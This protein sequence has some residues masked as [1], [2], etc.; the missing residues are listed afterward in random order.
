MTASHSRNR[1]GELGVIEESIRNCQ[2]CPLSKSRTNA[3]PGEGSYDARLMILGEAPG[4]KEDILGRP[5]VGRAGK[6]LRETLGD[7]GISASNVYITNIVRCRPPENRRPK[8]N[9][10]KTCTSHYLWKQIELIKPDIV[11]LLGAT[12]VRAILGKKS[13]G[14]LRGKTVE[15]AGQQYWVTYHPAAALYNVKQ[16]TVIRG[17]LR[18][19]KRLLDTKRRSPRKVRTT[20]VHGLI[21]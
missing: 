11:C 7:A 20:G 6:F 9:E 19:L 13:P 15:K 17:D 3:V 1:L 12:A 4:R 18:K 5:F 21:D 14:L 8:E 10:W 2:L 16:K